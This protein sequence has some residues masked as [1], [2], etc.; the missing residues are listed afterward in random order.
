[1]GAF[2]MT[3]Q[4]SPTIQIIPARTFRYT[5][6]MANYTHPETLVSTEWVE[7]HTNDP[8][9]T[10][11]EVDVDTR[12]SEEGHV[13]RAQAWAWNSQLCDTVRRDILSRE[14]FEQLM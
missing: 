3:L 9:V 5:W 10:V 4:R 13:P 1:M 6:P 11:V 8:G 12:A 14:H 7:Q 2:W